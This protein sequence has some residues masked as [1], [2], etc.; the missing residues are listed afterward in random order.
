DPSLEAA[1]RREVGE[2]TGVEIDGMEYVGS[3]RIDDWRYRGREDKMLSAFFA[4]TYIFGHPKA[5]DDIEEVRW[6]P[7]ALLPDCLIES[8]KEMGAR[9]LEFVKARQPSAAGSISERR[10][11]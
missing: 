11:P 8:H 3:F 4:A 1:C 6:V 7:L 5:E 10:M 9:L 2:E